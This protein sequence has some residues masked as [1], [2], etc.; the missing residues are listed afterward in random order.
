MKTTCQ[1]GDYARPIVRSQTLSTEDLVQLRRKALLGY[2]LR[3][4]YMF[5]T[6]RTIRS[7]KVFVNYMKSGARLIRNH[8]FNFGTATD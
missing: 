2:Y 8:S 5:D 7:P 3:P 1:K 6:L 4:S